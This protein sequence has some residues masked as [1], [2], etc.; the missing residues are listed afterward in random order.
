MQIIETK[1]ITLRKPYTIGTGDSAVV[2]DKLELREPTAGEFTDAGKAG[3]SNDVLLAL[4]QTVTKVPHQVVRSMGL[5]EMQECGGF[6][7]Q[8]S[9]D[10]QSP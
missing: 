9:N 5:R 3:D 2:Y 10:T 4:I 8:F 6:F 7:A 1:T